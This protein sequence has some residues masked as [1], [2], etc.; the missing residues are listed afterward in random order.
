LRLTTDLFPPV[1]S[2]VIIAAVLS[3]IMSTADSQLLVCASTVSHD[4]PKVKR[5]NIALDRLAIFVISVV[6]ITAALF[7][8]ETIFSTVLFAWSVLGA[9]FGP[10][11]LCRLLRGPVSGT[12]S[13]LSIWLGFS[14]TLVWYFTP[15]L[16]SLVY[17][18]VPAFTISLIP[19]WWGSREH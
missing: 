12:A 18:L 8:D 3:A 16:K 10:L 19:A 7:I 15:E 9:A 13:L 11:L 6:A 17:E 4:M 1:V 5:N 2:G 14:V